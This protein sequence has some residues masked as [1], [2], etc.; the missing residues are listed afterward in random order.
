MFKNL[1]LDCYK[2]KF[3]SPDVADRCFWQEIP[4]E[5]GFPRI[6]L[7]AL[8]SKAIKINRTDSLRVKIGASTTDPID[9]KE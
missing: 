2:V 5:M 9:T 8:Y 7:T 3:N 6:F 1:I 4:A